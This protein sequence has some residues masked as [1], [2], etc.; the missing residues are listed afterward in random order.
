MLMAAFGV[1]GAGDLDGDGVTDRAD[2]AIL[3]SGYGCG[4]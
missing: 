2:L 1:N 3:M 4:R